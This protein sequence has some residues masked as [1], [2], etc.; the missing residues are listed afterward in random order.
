MNFTAQVEL[1][2]SPCS[3]VVQQFIYG[4]NATL[5]FVTFHISCRS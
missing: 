2:K 3:L 1:Y 4:T 5:Q